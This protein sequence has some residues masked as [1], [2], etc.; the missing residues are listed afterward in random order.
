M[1]ALLWISAGLPAQD[2]PFLNGR[3]NDL[4]GLIPDN[5]EEGLEAR[6]EA[7][8]LETGS[9]VVILTVPDLQGARTAVVEGVRNVL[10]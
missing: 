9:Q 5:V 7:F 1:V 6:L 8:E 3:V 4:G 10:D 2:V